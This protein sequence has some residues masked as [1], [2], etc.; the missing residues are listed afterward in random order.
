MP[1]ATPAPHPAPT[2]LPSTARLR[3]RPAPRLDPPFEDECDRPP[4]GMDM[5]PLPGPV[6]V[7]TPRG[8][9]RPPSRHSS[10]RPGQTNNLIRRSYARPG[11]NSVLSRLSLF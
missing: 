8:A 7:G 1:V 6:L 5:L 4:A 9:R 3:V 11:R 10:R 2:G